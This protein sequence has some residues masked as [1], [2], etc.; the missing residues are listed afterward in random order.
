MPAL[1]LILF[2]A[3][4]LLLMAP[5]E[6]A[7]KTDKK[8]DKSGGQFIDVSPVAAPIVL[9][10]QLI[11]YIFVT[12]RLDLS[13]RADAIRL[14][15]KEPYFR[16]AFVRAAH[17]R[18]FVKPGDYTHLDEGDGGLIGQRR[19]RGKAEEAAEAAA[20]VPFQALTLLHFGGV[21]GP[22]GGGRGIKVLGRGW[23]RTLEHA[24]VGEMIAQHAFFRVGEIVEPVF[25]R[26]V[27]LV[28]APAGIAAGAGAI[29]WIAAEAADIGL[30]GVVE[31][32]GDS[33]MV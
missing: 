21:M 7:E 13:P 20:P 33:R 5:A 23:N 24:Q 15:D 32:A 28:E 3:V 19:A 12:L 17:R 6:A 2:S 10:G 14:R 22:Y 30:F 31:H 18:P 11:N 16:D 29:G 1:R 25:E 4:T 8:D 27:G 26:A 9:H